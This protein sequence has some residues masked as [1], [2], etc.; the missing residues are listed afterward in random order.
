MGAFRLLEGLDFGDR[1]WELEHRGGGTVLVQVGHNGCVRVGDRE[2]S[3]KW[4]DSR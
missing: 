2:R 1:W 3:E 4:M